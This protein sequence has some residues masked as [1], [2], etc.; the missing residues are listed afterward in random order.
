MNIKREQLSRSKFRYT[1]TLEPKLVR[2]HEAAALKA[3]GR[4]L[5]VPGFRKGHA[6]DEVLRQYIRADQLF[7]ETVREAVGSHTQKII[8]EE[9][10]EVI[11]APTVEV[12]KAASGNELVWRF[13]VDVMPNIDLGNWR[14]LKVIRKK[15]SVEA[16]EIEKAITFSQKSR[17][18]SIAVLRAAQKEDLVEI[19]FTTTHQ[20]IPVERGGK[21]TGYS[22][23]LGESNFV[24]GFDEYIVGMRA[25]ETKKFDLAFPATWWQK[26]VAGKTVTF[27]VTLKSVFELVLPERTDEFARSL[28]K[29]QDLGALRANIEEGLFTEKQQKEQERVN[30][31]VL[32]KISDRIQDADVPDALIEGEAT[33][34]MRELREA[35]G[36]ELKI[37]FPAYL[38]QIAKT[39]E[40]LKKSWKEPAR[41]RVKAALTLRTIAKAEGIEPSQGDVDEKAAEILRAMKSA[42]PANVVD[43]D[44][45][46]EYARAILRNEKTLALI[47]KTV[48]VDEA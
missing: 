13:S 23:V 16:E 27:T 30:A 48:V 3:M 35:V 44:R 20:G 41:E 9:R 40:A 38:A 17:A 25:G 28:G 36:R 34:M 26:E 10:L 45:V 11:T 46:E 24:P 19:G 31:E 42:E 12:L 7:N 8:Q 5:E 37:D 39:E 43:P 33:T 1:I 2:E 29:F 15:P 22:L 14:D 4:D 47:E 6:P 18:K 32:K 21:A